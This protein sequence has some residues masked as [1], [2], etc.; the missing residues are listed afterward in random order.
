[1]LKKENKKLNQTEN[2]NI[3][4]G[5]FL[6]FYAIFFLLVVFLLRTGYKENNQKITTKNS[7]YGYNFKLTRLENRNYHFIYTEELDN[8][9][10]VY[11]GNK[12][13]NTTK[14]KKSGSTVQEYIEDNK[15]VKYKDNNTL[16]W[17]KCENPM[18]FN[19]FT[20]PNYIKRLLTHGTYISKTMYINNSDT[21]YNYDIATSTIIKILDKKEIDIDDKPNTISI[22]LDSTGKIKEIKYDLTSYY[23]YINPDALSYKISQK[24]SKYGEIKEIEL[25]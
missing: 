2:N 16:T 7:G 8:N 5:L 6:G 18:F 24:Y 3:K 15:T 10:V 25:P 22:I 9:L 4:S 11:E 14:Y 21:A 12:F 20:N 13:A 17:E 19:K 23:K 1:M